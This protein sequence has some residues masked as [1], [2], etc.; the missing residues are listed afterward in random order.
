MCSPAH[1][2]FC[3]ELAWL[4]FPRLQAMPSR[5]WWGRTHGPL[6]LLHLARGEEGDGVGA[7][8]SP[9]HPRHLLRMMRSPTTKATMAKMSPP[10]RMVS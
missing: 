8:G 1:L 2:T 3:W 4:E 9:A 6:P 5:P 7:K 10:L